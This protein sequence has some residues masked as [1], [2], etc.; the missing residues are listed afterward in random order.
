[1]LC[2][3]SHPPDCPAH[4]VSASG[5]LP[6]LFLILG[7]HPC[8]CLFSLCLVS[9]GSWLLHSTPLPPCSEPGSVSSLASTGVYGST[10]AFC[11]RREPH[12]DVDL[13]GMR[14]RGVRKREGE[15]VLEGKTRKEVPPILPLH[16]RSRTA[17]QVP[18]DSHLPSSRDRCGQEGQRGHLRKAEMNSGRFREHPATEKCPGR[19]SS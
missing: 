1:M 18:Q 3:P 14:R 17:S 9:S 6:F 16:H 15:K 4:V 13:V 10:L 19:G 11:L 7:L 12:R 5:F 8:P 2:T